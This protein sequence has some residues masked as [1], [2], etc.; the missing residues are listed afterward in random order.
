MLRSRPKHALLTPAPR[1]AILG[2]MSNFLSGN[3]LAEVAALVGDA[4]RANMLLALMGGRALTAGELAWHAGVSAQTASGHLAKLT[5]A[6][7]L[8][9]EKQGRHRYYRLSG[10]E[11]AEA[12]EALMAMA[13]SGPKRHRP[14]GPRDEAMRLARTCYDH[15]AGRLGVAL[16]DSLCQRGHLVLSEGAGLVTASGQDF[17]AGIGIELETHPQ[18]KRPLCR[19]CIDWSERRPHLAGRLGAALLERTLALNWVARVPE[20]RTIRITPAGEQGL[21]QRFAISVRRLKDA[22]A[23]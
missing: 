11:V 6:H 1:A 17:L 14:T 19:S 18:G 16:A 13:A 12:V 23:P 8:A 3:T 10:G 15:L 7:M 2:G 20:S 4:A 22:S 21:A 9:V 5:D